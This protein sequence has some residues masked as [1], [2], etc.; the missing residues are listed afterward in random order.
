M[1]H[2]YDFGSV[3]PPP[4]LIV[5]LRRHPEDTPPYFGTFD[6][7][8]GLATSC[9]GT[10]TNILTPWTSLTHWADLGGLVQSWP[11]PAAP[12]AP[13]QDPFWTPPTDGQRVWLRRWPGDAASIPAMWV[14]ATREFAVY[15]STWVIPWHL[16][17]KWK[18]R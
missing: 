6:F 7:V 4:G 12:G 11:R 3:A 14:N 13:W 1:S 18:R 8:T 10:G 17:W 2:W 16:V 9:V 5:R 15:G